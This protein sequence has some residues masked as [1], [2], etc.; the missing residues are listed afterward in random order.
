MPDA[1][2]G[3]KPIAFGDFSYY[4]VVLRAPF[5]LRV[6]TDKFVLN[7]QI[8]YLALEYLDGKLV[9]IDAVKVLLMTA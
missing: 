9:R 1:A 7:D 6:L 3:N 4:W 5:S 8:G 2:T